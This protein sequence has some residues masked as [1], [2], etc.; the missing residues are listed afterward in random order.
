[1]CFRYSTLPT[2][3]LSESVALYDASWKSDPIYGTEPT[4]IGKDVEGTNS[5]RGVL[6]GKILLRESHLMQTGNKAAKDICYHLLKRFC[7]ANHCLGR[8]LDP[9]SQT[10]YPF[11]YRLSWHLLQCLQALGQLTDEEHQLCALL[12]TRYAAQLEALGSWDWAVFVLLH[13]GDRHIRK[14]LIYELLQRNVH[15]SR[16]HMLME[17]TE[18]PQQETILQPA[19]IEQSDASNSINE[20]DLAESKENFLMNQLH[21]PANWIYDAKVIT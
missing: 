19:A 21:I 20:D 6:N 9:S 12:T 5:V 10:T 8:A 18:A 1:M 3:A 15:I 17:S 11:D 4:A 13:L 16:A 14:R 2:S 7:K